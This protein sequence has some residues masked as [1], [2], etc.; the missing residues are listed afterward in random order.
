[1]TRVYFILA[2]LV[3]MAGA[4]SLSGV[5]D[6]MDQAAQKFRSLSANVQQTDYTDVLGDTESSSGTFKM[7]KAGKDK[8]VFLANFTGKDPHEVHLSGNEVEMYYP[9]ANTVQIY[10]TR[11]LTKSMDQYLL[12][13][14][15]TRSAELTKTYNV[16]LGGPETVA[17]VKTTRIDLA[18]RSAEAKK[19]FNMI[20]LW[21][22]DGEGSPIQEKM[23]SGKRGED[24]KL[25]RF[26]N[27]KIYTVSDP[28]VP[29]SE[30]ELNLPAGV[31]RQQVK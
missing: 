25:F 1:M 4:E 12:V 28:A 11:K 22:P 3:P 29:A 7:M 18:P 31:T 5:L 19:L 16:T 30:F 15:G 24:Y 14:F 8:F 10:D 20:Q 9:K 21:I 2:L 6:R 17:G 27:R 13:G 26:S 23:I